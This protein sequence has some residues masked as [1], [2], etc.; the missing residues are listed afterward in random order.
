MSVGSNIRHI[1]EL[2]GL[3]QKELGLKCGFSA[4]TADVRIRQYEADKMVLGGQIAVNFVGKTANE[5]GLEG[6]CFLQQWT[7]RH[8]V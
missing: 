3:T 8:V 4:S 7:E 1:R 2:R 5:G 6:T